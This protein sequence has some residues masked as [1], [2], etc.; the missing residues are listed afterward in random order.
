MNIITE[1][2]WEYA[3][4]KITSGQDELVL[5]SASVNDP[6]RRVY[7]DRQY[8]YKVVLKS[9][10]SRVLRLNTLEQEYKI[11]QKCIIDG[12]ISFAIPLHAYVKYM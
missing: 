6:Y 4:Q 2:K 10:V 7:G 5:I 8:C 3:L 1:A 9:D 12:R 11:L